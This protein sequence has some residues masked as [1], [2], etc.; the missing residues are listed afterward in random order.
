[1]QTESTVAF[2][3][4]KNTVL[5]YGKF[6]YA[7][8]SVELFTF[9]IK[10]SFGWIR[11]YSSSN[12]ST[13]SAL[14][15]KTSIKIAAQILGDIHENGST[16]MYSGLD[17]SKKYMQKLEWRLGSPT[18]GWNSISSLAKGSTA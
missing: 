11:K 13:V 17:L 6:F 7:I 4:T 5:H 14:L 18:P 15:D 9:S 10:N 16:P 8:Y 12:L 1:M 2:Y 3:S